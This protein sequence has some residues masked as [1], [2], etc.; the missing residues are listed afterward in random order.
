MVDL[1]T[2]V[3]LEQ[4]VLGVLIRSGEKG[5]R[6]LVFEADA[7]LRG[8][9]VFTGRRRGIY[10]SIL[11]TAKKGAPPTR[12]SV[13]DVL[14]G[15]AEY[16][17]G[18]AENVTTANRDA[19]FMAVE[20]VAELHRSR[21]V[22]EMLTTAISGVRRGEDVE[23]IAREVSAQL[24]RTV[25]RQESRGGTIG[26][27]LDRWDA[28]QRAT[29]TDPESAWHVEWGIWD[30]DQK[31]GRLFRGGHFV[32]VGAHT[33][34]GKTVIATDLLRANMTR[35]LRPVII[36]LEQAEEDLLERLLSAVGSVPY[37]EVRDNAVSPANIARLEAARGIIR[38]NTENAWLE[39]IPGGQL[40]DV[41]A[42][43]R[44]HVAQYRARLVIVDYV[45]IVAVPRGHS[46]Q[47]EVADIVR[48]L[49]RLALELGICIVGM[50]Q[51][52]DDITNRNGH[53]R[54][55]FSWD[56][57]EA[58]D[59]EKDADAVVL[60]DRP[61]HRDDDCFW[62][63]DAAKVSYQS[64]LIEVARIDFA[65]ARRAESFWKP[66]WW[67]GQYQRFAEMPPPSEIQAPSWA[68]AKD[69][70]VW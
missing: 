16:V 31:I 47:S 34:A 51:L 4:Q 45:Q 15:E 39:H 26:T 24:L 38:A 29:L 65:R 36:G 40:R 50:C 58:K 53:K 9:E 35:D 32:A 7:I 68:S 27:I 17:R 57:R 5:N 2:N 56:V 10:A 60:I 64:R 46:R 59:I 41:V 30:I 8:D 22:C 42:R 69:E 25:E 20:R 19:F 3:D 6:D 54:R 63:G 37:S 70:E 52:N 28:R 48:T 11:E 33:K 14:R 23:G 21:M 44:A 18:V 12:T 67:Q 1:L 55:P 66:V 62:D 13:A 49:K 43:I 61:A